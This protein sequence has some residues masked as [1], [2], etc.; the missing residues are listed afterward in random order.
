ML[1]FITCVPTVLHVNS[2]HLKMWAVYA[3][4]LFVGPGWHL[5]AR[6]ESQIHCAFAC[7]SG[8]MHNPEYCFT[9]NYC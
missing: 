6:E 9:N 4:R 2:L 7:I 8:E 5:I 3:E 1:S